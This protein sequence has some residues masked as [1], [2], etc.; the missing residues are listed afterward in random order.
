M[1]LTGLAAV[2]SS[3]ST[4]SAS[5]TPAL[6][7]TGL[8]A[9]VQ[10]IHFTPVGMLKS[11]S[12]ST[13]S[14]GSLKLVTGMVADP[15][16]PGSTVTSNGVTILQ[17]K[18][19][20]TITMSANCTNNFTTTVTVAAYKNGVQIGTALTRTGGSGTFT[21]TGSVTGAAVTAGDVITM[22]ASA[23]NGTTTI[24]VADTFLNV[25]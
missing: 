4:V 23:A 2:I 22:M 1:T 21:I 9:D 25:T 24:N 13:V 6:T 3:G 20:A 18:S 15:A 11:G 7:L 5:T 19:D 14:S 12:S 8:A 16:F 17:S 10:T